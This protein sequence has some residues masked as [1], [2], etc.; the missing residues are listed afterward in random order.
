M[1]DL[2]RVLR[3][4]FSL[5]VCHVSKINLIGVFRNPFMAEGRCSIGQRIFMKKFVDKFIISVII[6]ISVI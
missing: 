4:K 3:D 6:I 5:F 2:I 1:E